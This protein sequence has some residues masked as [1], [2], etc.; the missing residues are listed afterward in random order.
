MKMTEQKVSYNAL[1]L[2]RGLA[3]LMIVFHHANADCIPTLPEVG[4]VFSWGLW[5]LRNV[6]WTAVDL[7][8][9]LSGFFFALSVVQGLDR[10]RFNLRQYYQRRASRIIPTYYVLVAVLALCG[11]GIVFGGESGLSPWVGI[12]VYFTFLHNY[13]ASGVCGPVWFLGVI[14]HAYLFL[15]PFFMALQRRSKKSL[16]SKMGFLTGIVLVGTLLARTAWYFFGPYGSNHFMFSHFRM[17][18]LFVGMFVFFSVRENASWVQW[19]RK[20]TAASALTC[21][22]LISIAMFCARDTAY[23][24]TAGYSLLAIAYGGLIVL[25]TQD[26]ANERSARLRGLFPLAGW[27]YGIYLWHWYLIRIFPQSY[28]RFF[29]WIASVE[30]GAISSTLLQ[31]GAFFL[32]SLLVGVASTR[33]IEQPAVRLFFLKKRE[34]ILRHK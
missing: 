7:F 31:I 6:G 14:V 10:G 9:V 3:G 22:A 28:E 18:A 11:T 30:V 5:R 12:P 17:D 25:L 29:L 27:S 8:F 19:V 2:L 24:F 16:S 20:Y 4:G 34:E 33:W 26:R 21:L 32:I 1:T 23:M 15:P 13:L